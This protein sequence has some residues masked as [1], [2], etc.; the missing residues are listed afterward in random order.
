MHSEWL[1]ITLIID[2]WLND[3]FRLQCSVDRLGPM[4]LSWRRVDNS[5]TSGSSYLATGSLVMSANK[6]ISLLS[7]TT[8]STL[9]ITLVRPEDE[10]ELSEILKIKY[11]LWIWFLFLGQYVCEVSSSPPVH[12]AHWLKLTGQI[13]EWSIAVWF[14]GFLFVRRKLLWK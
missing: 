6:R 7:S 10:G 14:L 12:M 1:K 11:R 4:V 13:N 5:S 9:L 2:S 3:I 8:S